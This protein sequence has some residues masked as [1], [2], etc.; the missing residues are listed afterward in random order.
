MK[1]GSAPISA[2]QEGQS[3]AGIIVVLDT[4]PG[5]RWAM[6]KGLKRSGYDVRAVSTSGDALGLV[7]AEPVQAVIMEIL[8]EAGLTPEVLTTILEAPSKPKVVC[9]SLESE[10]KAIIECVR[11][12]AADFIPKP[13]NLNDVRAVLRRSLASGPE[14]R[15]LRRPW[16]GKADA[17]ASYLVGV[18]PAM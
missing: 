2:E 9:I 6:E 8:P 14:Q 10:P 16:S 4:D 3:P 5:V 13:F 12:G 18:S 1:H 7:Y 11:R 15:V 17:E